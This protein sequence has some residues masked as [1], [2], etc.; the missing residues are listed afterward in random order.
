[1]SPAGSQL[2]REPGKYNLNIIRPLRHPAEQRNNRE[3]AEDKQAQDPLLPLTCVPN[4]CTKPLNEQDVNSREV[5]GQDNK[6]RCHESKDQVHTQIQL[7]QPPIL[8]TFPLII[9]AATLSSLCVQ[10]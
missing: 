8:G 10:P 2:I 9:R 6:E 7:Y 5:S 3:V 1:M 4:I